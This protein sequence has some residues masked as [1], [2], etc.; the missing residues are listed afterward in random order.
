M[1]VAEWKRMIETRIGDSWHKPRSWEEL[2]RLLQAY[3]GC[4]DYD[5]DGDDVEK[6]VVDTTAGADAAAF[7][8]SALLLSMRRWTFHTVTNILWFSNFFY[9]LYYIYIYNMYIIYI[10]RSVAMKTN[11]T[12]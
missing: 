1:Y 5:M 3:G 12:I 6:I 4:T 9:I 2:Q 8:S 11:I 10:N 7:G